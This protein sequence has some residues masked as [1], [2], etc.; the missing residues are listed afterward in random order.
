MLE[1][2]GRRAWTA[3]QRPGER[4]LVE[5]LF[6]VVRAFSLHSHAS[7]VGRHPELVAHPGFD[8]ERHV[9]MLFE[10]FAH[11]VLA[12]PDARARIA[13]PGARFVDD[14]GLD[15]EVDDFALAGD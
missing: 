5:R 15:A 3:T 2:P 8:L 12:L 13:E 7:D 6:F 4:E 10:V 1:P 9:G 14:A 11:V